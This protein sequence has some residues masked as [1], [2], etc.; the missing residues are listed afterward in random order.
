LND[1]LEILIKKWQS[2]QEC[3]QWQY[4]HWWCVAGGSSEM[5]GFYFFP[6]KAVLNIHNDRS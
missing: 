1:G 5:S 4:R 2:S 3:R 6:D